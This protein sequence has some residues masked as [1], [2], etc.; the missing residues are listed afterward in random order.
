[1]WKLINSTIAIA[2]L[3]VCAILLTHFKGFDAEWVT[4]VATAVLAFTAIIGLVGIL[5][6][7]HMEKLRR[8]TQHLNQLVDVVLEPIR[9]ELASVY[10]GVLARNTPL[11]SWSPIE[12]LGLERHPSGR[13]A[14]LRP[15]F[16]NPSKDSIYHNLYIHIAEYHYPKIISDYELFKKNYAT[17][18]DEL[19]AEAKNLQ[20]LVEVGASAL[21]T[22]DGDPTNWFPGDIARYVFNRLWMDGYTYKLTVRIGTIQSPAGAWVLENVASS[23]TYAHGDERK[24]RALHEM[25][26]ALIASKNAASLIENTKRIQHHLEH[27][28]DAL[29]KVQTVE[30]LVGDC[31]VLKGGT[32]IS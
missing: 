19:L 29:A 4:A 20:K 24:M 11:L 32:F 21:S 2:L 27:L 13:F 30:T 15:E 9:G 28:L 16:H 17:L 22:S 23:S 1:M 3:V 10:G 14:Y 5:I 7:L 12:G 26:E 8:R 25:V 18:C 31:P 6:P